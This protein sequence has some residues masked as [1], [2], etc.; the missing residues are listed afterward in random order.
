MKDKI[1]VQI[2]ENVCTGIF[3]WENKKKHRIIIGK[4]YFHVQNMQLLKTDE[5]IFIQKM[6]RV[7]GRGYMVEDAFIL[8]YVT[9]E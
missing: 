8:R 1:P 7:Y 2:L 9:G 6:E 3:V 4:M 5:E